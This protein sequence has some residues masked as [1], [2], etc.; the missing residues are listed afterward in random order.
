M[1]SLEIGTLTALRLASVRTNVRDE[2]EIGAA[3]AGLLT[4]L[5]DRLA[6]HGVADADIVLTYDGTDDDTIVVTAGTTGSV[7]ATAPGVD[8]LGL[9]VVDLPG[10]DRGVTVRFDTPPTSIGDAWL[11]VDAELENRSLTTTGV[12]RQT[13][14][15]DGGVVLQAP[16]RDRER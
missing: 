8:V 10:T 4:D 16:V 1:N 7:G 3:A 15:A 6:D 9:D 5:R 11:T 12:Y 14:T 2:S 13:L